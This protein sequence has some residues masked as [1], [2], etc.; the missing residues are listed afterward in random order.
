M[1]DE[2][3]EKPDSMRIKKLKELIEELNM[4][5]GMGEAE[6]PSEMESPE[7]EAGE[8]GKPALDVAIIAD[9]K[10]KC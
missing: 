3:E 10:P 8:H 5:V 7:M 1:L 2:M 6:E 9:K 4:L